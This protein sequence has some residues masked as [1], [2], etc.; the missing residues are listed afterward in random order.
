M[1]MEVPRRK[2]LTVLR[3]WQSLAGSQW[4]WPWLARH[5]PRRYGLD[6]IGDPYLVPPWTPESCRPIC[7][8]RKAYSCSASGSASHE[9]T[10]T[11]GTPLT[12]GCLLTKSKLLLVLIVISHRIQF[13]RYLWISAYPTLI[14]SLDPR[15]L[16][17]AN[18]NKL[19]NKKSR[20]HFLLRKR[21]W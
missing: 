6:K 9:M 14:C 11:S 19:P 1:V 10:S 2:C 4:Q 15:N 21:C 12:V 20:I 7:P 16:P 13:E 8:A 5:H 17:E 3:L 18:L